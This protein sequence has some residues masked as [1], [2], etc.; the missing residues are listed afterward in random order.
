M[1][2]G[3]PYQP[4]PT[5]QPPAQPYPP[6]QPAQQPVYYPPQYPQAPGGY[7]AQY[8]APA[9]V[10]PAPLPTGGL[11]EY[12]AQPSGG[13]GPAYKFLDSNRQPQIGKEYVGLVARQPGNGDI[14]AQ[15]DPRGMPQFFKD[16]RPKFVMVCPMLTMPSTE[17]P[18][19][20]AGWWVKGQARDELARAM[21]EAGAPV[22]PPEA[23]A[24]I[25]VRLTGSRPVPGMNPALIFLVRYWLPSSAEAAQ[26]A[27]A[28]NQAAPY[29]PPAPI[30][31]GPS[32]GWQQ[33]Y[34]APAPQQPQYAPPPGSPYAAPAPQQYAPPPAAAAPV[35]PGPPAG[36]TGY[37][38]PAAPTA[39]PQPLQMPAN[40]TAEQQA[41]WAQLV[42]TRNV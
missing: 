40:L 30:P 15:T 38:S 27:A 12:Y 22:G 36:A 25:A 21:A 5:P 4:Y 23:G 18:D 35:M 32:A 20:N 17:F 16:G 41:Q 10:P 6:Q 8:G 26:F 29:T 2:P 34:A 13:S 9:P 39:A 14:R 3:Y 42:A 24:L 31:P 37:A 28:L 1:Q 19:G 11:D 7:P 33:G